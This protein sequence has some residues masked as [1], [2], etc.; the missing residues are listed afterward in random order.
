LEDLGKGNALSEIMIARKPCRIAPVF[1]NKTL[2]AWICIIL[3]Q[4]AG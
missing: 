4:P 2:P 3:R 1:S